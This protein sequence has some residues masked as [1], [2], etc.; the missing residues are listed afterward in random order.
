MAEIELT[1][2]PTHRRAPSSRG[3]SRRLSELRVPDARAAVHRLRAASFV[4]D[5]FVPED[6]LQAT[7][8]AATNVKQVQMN[9]ATHEAVRA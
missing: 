3:V 5:P 9:H 1:L 4:H 8:F 2:P 7:W 6:R